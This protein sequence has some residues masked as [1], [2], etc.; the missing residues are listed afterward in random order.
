[1]DKYSEEAFKYRQEGADI[2]QNVLHN[3]A[4]SRE[5]EQKSV[6][7]HYDAHYKLREAYESLAKEYELLR[8]QY[9]QMLE[10]HIKCLDRS[11]T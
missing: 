6:A 2:W 1:M 9:T 5:I 7:M 10:E 3:L 4:E 11:E 8:N